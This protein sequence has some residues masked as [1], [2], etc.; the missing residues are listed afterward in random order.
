MRIS[1]WS[2]DVC[3][4]DLIIGDA[5]LCEV[6]T[7]LKIGTTALVLS[8]IEAGYLTRPLTVEGSVAALR[9]VSHDPTCKELIPLHD[10]RKL[11]GVQ[12]QMEY[13]DLARK[14]VDAR[15]GSDADAQTVD[16]LER[17]VSV[18]TRPERD[19]MARSSGVDW[20]PTPNPLY[21]HRK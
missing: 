9:A 11:T 5:N 16:V 14:F 19:P 1:D 20:G 4:S 6:S 17:W 10:G 21:H 18:L 15:L 2:S 3:S 12:P 7:Y 13:L 8:M